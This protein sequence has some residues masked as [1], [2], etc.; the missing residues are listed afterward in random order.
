MTSEKSHQKM[1]FCY[2]VKFWIKSLFLISRLQIWKTKCSMLLCITV[3]ISYKIFTSIQ[4]WFHSNNMKVRYNT[5]VSNAISFPERGHC[6]F[7][8][9]F[10][11]FY[12]N[13]NCSVIS[14]RLYT[15]FL[16]TILIVSIIYIWFI[17][18]NICTLRQLEPNSL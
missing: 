16:E 15:Y 6:R 2:F 9:E 5:I 18:F 14:L 12:T 13:T 7:L 4:L 17:K 8:F 3:C 11:C 1:F 10:C